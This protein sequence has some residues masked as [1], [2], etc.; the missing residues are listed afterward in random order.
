M[1]DFKKLFE[2]SPDAY[3]VLSPAAPHTILA[4]NDAYLSVTGT[5]REDLLGRGLFEIFPDN[6]ATPEAGSTRELSLSL[7]RAASL[8]QR[9][10]MA[11]QRYDI[12]KRSGPGVDFEERFWRVENVPLLATDGSVESLLHRVEDITHVVRLEE[13]ERREAEHATLLRARAESARQ[14]IASRSSELAETR[15]RLQENE[16]QLQEVAVRLEAAATAGGIGTWIWEPEADRLFA[17]NTVANWY[18]VPADSGQSGSLRAYLEAVHPDDLAAV[19]DLVART[20]ENG[21]TLEATYRIRRNEEGSWRWVIARA[22]VQRDK[23]NRPIRLVGVVLDI[24]DLQQARLALEQTQDQLRLAAEAAE[25]GSFSWNVPPGE[26]VWDAQCKAHFWLPPDADVNLQLFYARMHPEDRE[27]T[28]AAVEAAIVSD[29]NYDIE[30]RTVSASGQIRWVHAKGRVHRTSSGAAIRFAGITL[31]VSRQK[32]M[33]TELRETEARYRMVVS[34][35][36]EHAIFMLDDEGRVTHWNQGA[37]RLLGYS[38]AEMIGRSGQILF[39]PEDQA[40]GEHEREIATAK[41]TGSAS[42]DRWHLRKDGSRFFVTGLMSA[43]LDAQGRRIGL[44]K[45]MRDSTERQAA[46]A[47]REHLLERERAARAEAERTSRLKDD[48]LA[49]LSH[50]LRTPLNAIFGWTQILK[51]GD[52]E[53]AD[54]EQGLDVIER[55]ARVQ[56][57][58]IEDL[59]DM[60][61]IISGKVRLDVQT[62]S[63]ASAVNAAMDTVRTAAEA[64]EIRLNAVFHGAGATVI[65]DPNRLQQIVWNLLS[66]AIKFTPRN[67]RVQV[68]VSRDADSVLIS[69]S[70]NGIGIHPDF[71]PHVFERFRQGDASTTRQHT[72][73]GLG[74]SIV[75]QLVELHGGQVA[76]ESAGEGRGA[77]FSVSIPLAAPRQAEPLRVPRPIPPAAVSNAGVDLA[78]IKVLIVDDEPDSGGVVKRVLERHRAEVQMAGSMDE[79]LEAL[80]VFRPDVLLSDIG[81]PRHDGYELIRR[82]RSLPLGAGI[83]AAALTALARNEDRAR[84]LQAGF[85]AHVSKPVEPAELISVVSRLAG[86]TVP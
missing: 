85:H 35:L 63:I 14:E 69:V 51:S 36:H 56:V 34:N 79:A 58:L 47:E 46:A 75:K 38:E 19:Q 12:P 72:G 25:I 41:A 11:R 66:N 76:A 53:P 21:A 68:S 84:A 32:Q 24:S 71:L 62:V 44:A 1:S 80:A 22:R 20:L 40:R 74:L 55:N 73:L 31:D 61:R 70:D 10:L 23:K 81:M 50:E 82:V 28:R 15:Q 77:T 45:I 86:R 5:R 7:K 33:E 65:A 17:D 52:L 3:L 16:Q 18:N 13:A 48:F 59:L 6:P 83:P 29:D 42:D 30:F 57:K 26:L 54:L 39:T 37:E 27:R 43:V 4:V 49:T 64:K 2:A 9:Q 67:G 60:S 8:G 78:G